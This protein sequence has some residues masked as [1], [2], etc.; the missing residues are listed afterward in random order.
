MV[1]RMVGGVEGQFSGSAIV[2]LDFGVVVIDDTD[3]AVA[4]MAA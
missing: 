3:D 1:Y 2:A 4:L